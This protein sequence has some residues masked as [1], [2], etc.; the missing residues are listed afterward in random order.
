MKGSFPSAT[1]A[2]M[3]A[4][5]VSAQFP[6]TITLTDGSSGLPLV[7]ASVVLD[8][9]TVATDASGQAVFNGLADAT[10]DFWATASCY[11][12]GG[13]SVTIAGAAASEGLELAPMATNNIFW[14]IGDP[15]AITGASVHVYNATGYDTTFV[16]WDFFGGEMLADVPFGTV[17]YTITTPCYETVSGTVTVDCNNGDGILVVEDPAP[18]ATNNLFWYIGDPLAITGASVHVYNSMG[19]DTTFV[20]WD[21]FGGEML[22]DVPFGTVDYTI[23]TPCYETVSGSVTV[24][25][26]NGDGIL[27]ATD[28]APV[29]IDATVTVAGSTLNASATGVAYQWVDCNNG[30]VPIDGATGQSFTP[31]ESGNYAVVISEEGCTAMSECTSMV[32][33]GHVELVP[34]RDFTTF[35]V[36]FNEQIT[37]GVNDGAGQ[38]HIAM[39]DQLGQRVL[40]TSSLGYQVVVSTADLP[41]GSYLLRIRTGRSQGMVHIVK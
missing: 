6:A 20:T 12:P 32:I 19:Y 16:T 5:Q 22:A 4:V 26:N 11:S 10:Y 34:G 14:Y 1:L 39:F 38:V 31:A 7:N 28:P 35:P 36:P 18:M 29:V 9:N 27:V 8:G 3:L 13:G 40:Q 41:P 33:T 17:D 21:F 23:T 15:L 24:D 30:N 25:C 37:I 2:A